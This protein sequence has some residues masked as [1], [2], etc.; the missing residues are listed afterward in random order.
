MAALEAAMMTKSFP[1]IPS[2]TSLKKTM[3]VSYLECVVV[4]D[5]APYIVI[6]NR[7]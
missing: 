2:R 7:C 3:I 1:V 4:K 5:E 6:G